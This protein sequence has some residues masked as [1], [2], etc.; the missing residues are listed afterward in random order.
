MTVTFLVHILVSIE[1]NLLPKF[2]VYALLCLKVEVNF[3]PKKNTCVS[4]YMKF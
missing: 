1:E 4:V 2:F 3:R